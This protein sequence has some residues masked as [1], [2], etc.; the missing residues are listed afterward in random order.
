VIAIVKYY[1]HLSKLKIMIP[2]SLTGFTGYFILQPYI[3]AH[4]LFVSLGILLFGI[5]AS[6]LNQVQ[7]ADI[8]SRMKR[9][10]D[11]P[12]PSGSISKRNA[13]LFF[14]STLLSG[15][16]L[17]LVFGNI[18]ALSVSFF[19]VFW[20]N[21]V[22]TYSKRVTPFAVFPG[23][24]TGALP[25]L[26]G[27]LAA[28]GGFFDRTIVMV[29]FLFFVGQMPHFW[30]IVLKYGEEYEKAGLPCLTRIMKPKQISRLIFIWIALSGIAAVFLYLFGI[31]HTEFIAVLVLV[32]T[33]LLIVM[34]AGLL[35]SGKW[36]TKLNMY[37]LQLNVY[38]LLII[39]FIV[40]DRLISEFLL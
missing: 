30:I 26:I 13:I 25:P 37:N 12:I 2:V 1:F 33:I 15:S 16:L 7:E 20:Y 29:E 39:V 22:Y 5:A 38:F 19:T 21:F 14:L 11:R 35:R 17:I 32:S 6:V 9:T 34:S 24:I 31:I 27:W 4:I 18:K 28:G 40:S 3:S 10:H 36:K 23:A 8:D